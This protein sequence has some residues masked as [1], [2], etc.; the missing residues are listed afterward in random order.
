[1]TLKELVRKLAKIHP[2]W[3]LYGK[4]DDIVWAT[5]NTIDAY[6][7]D[8]NTLVIKSPNGKHSLKLSW[9]TELVLPR[10]TKDLVGSEKQQREASM[11]ID[12]PGAVDVAYQPAKDVPWL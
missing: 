10:Y 6:W 1:M 3:M 4:R 12:T 5:P 9:W 8:W 11:V 2:C 7:P